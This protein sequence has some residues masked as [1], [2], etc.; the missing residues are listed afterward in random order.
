MWID[1]TRNRT[2]L[3]ITHPPFWSRESRNMRHDAAAKWLAEHDTAA[4]A[5]P[6]PQPK[7]M[8]G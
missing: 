1:G 6:D 7:L 5:E 4:K 3:A 8:S 2:I